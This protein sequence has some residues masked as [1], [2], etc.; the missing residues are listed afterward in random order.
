MCYFQSSSS[1]F[2]YFQFFFQVSSSGS[3]FDLMI[4]DLLEGLYVHN[5]SSPHTIIQEWNLHSPF[6]TEV[7][8]EFASI[9][10]YEDV[11]LFM[12]TKRN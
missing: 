1:F 4:V 7:L 10:L 8:F 3:K 11:C 5:V 2:Y 12:R 6:D 9:Y